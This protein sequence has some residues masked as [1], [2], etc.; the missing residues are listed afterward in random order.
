MNSVQQTIDRAQ[1]TLQFIGKFLDARIG[2]ISLVDQLALGLGQ[3]LVAIGERMMLPLKKF[4]HFRHV[5]RDNLEGLLAQ[6]RA[7]AALAL[8]Q[9][10]NTK[11]SHLECPGPKVAPSLEL[12]ELFPKRGTNLL[13]CILRIGLVRNHGPN[14][15]I[16]V[17]GLA[18]VER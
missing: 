14:E 2:S 7:G 5:V 12:V 10:R 8:A 17:L 16:Y 3:F 11:A 13:E 9:V 15:L 4:V 6:L 18:G 1:W